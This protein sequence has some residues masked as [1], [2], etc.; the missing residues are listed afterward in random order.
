MTRKS[1]TKGSGNV[2]LDL[3]FD[4]VEAHVLQAR[5][6][7]MSDLRIYIREN[8]LT[9]A[10]AAKMLGVTQGR[11]SDLVRGKWEKFSLEM[12]MTLEGRLG[13]RVDVKIAA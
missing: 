4:P 7:L 11:V 5:A 1:S 2:F 12:L 10:R 3:G 8:K 6:N 9:Q 13:R